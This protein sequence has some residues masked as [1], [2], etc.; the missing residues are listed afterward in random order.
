VS[1]KEQKF[2]YCPNIEQTCCNEEDEERIINLW[3]TDNKHRIEHYY[4]NFLYAIKFLLGYGIQVEQVA[5]RV[6][7]DPNFGSR[8]CSGKAKDFLEMNM[9]RQLI[10]EVF[11][12]I[13]QSLEKVSNLRRGNSFLNYSVV[14][15]KDFTV[16]YVM[17]RLSKIFITTGSLQSLTITSC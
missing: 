10:K 2:G 15:L 17:H 8:D 12:S 14:N 16:T 6:K 3:Y 7:S 4:E 9:N 13:V 11:Y 5:K 1:T